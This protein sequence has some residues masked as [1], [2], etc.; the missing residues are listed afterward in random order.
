MATYIALA[1]FTTKGIE[2]IGES[3][4]RYDS[5]REQFEK[6]GVKIKDLYWTM[7]RY[8]VVNIMEAPDDMTMVRMGMTIGSWGYLR[9][10][11]LRAFTRDEFRQATES[12]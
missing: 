5:Q 7:G 8:D 3:Y 11:T 6:I 2:G 1:K 9:T 4:K 12:L 10:E